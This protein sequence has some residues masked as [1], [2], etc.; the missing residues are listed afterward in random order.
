MFLPILLLLE[1]PLLSLSQQKTYGNRTLQ[2]DTIYL[3][4]G[5]NFFVGAIQGPQF[6]FKYQLDRVFHL[7]TASMTFVKIPGLSFVFHHSRPSIYKIY[8]QGM[9]YANNLDCRTWIRMMIDDQVLIAN[10]LYPNTEGRFTIDPSIGRDSMAIDWRAGIY[11]YSL[12]SVIVVPSVKREVVLIAAGTHSI[13]IGIRTERGVGVHGAELSLEIIE[14]DE[15]SKT[16]LPL[17]Q[18]FQG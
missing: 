16:N 13:D 15:L 8:F 17:L 5:R 6:Y 18:S 4:R 2:T 10:K 3:D 1:L 14:L 7:N 11:V 9:V 12:S